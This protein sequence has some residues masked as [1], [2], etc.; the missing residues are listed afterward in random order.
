M[1]NFSWNCFE[2]TGDIDAYLLFKDA[3][4]LSQVEEAEVT[5]GEEV[6]V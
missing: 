3:D 2:M 1:R 4:L 6:E 5:L